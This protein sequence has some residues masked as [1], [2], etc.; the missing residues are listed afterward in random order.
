M[1]RSTVLRFGHGFGLAEIPT[2]AFLSP[3]AYSAEEKKMQ[4]AVPSGPALLHKG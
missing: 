2:G 3:A 1:C 4:V